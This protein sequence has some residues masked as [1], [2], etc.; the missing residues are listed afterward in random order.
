MN[1]KKKVTKDVRVIELIEKVAELYFSNEPT[2]D[3]IINIASALG[4]Y[5]YQTELTKTERRRYRHRFAS[6]IDEE[7]SEEVETI[8][9]LNVY[10]KI[11]KEVED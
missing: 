10:K 7:K 1:R 11:T 8:Y 2:N 4:D 6:Y 5:N 3:D 9:I